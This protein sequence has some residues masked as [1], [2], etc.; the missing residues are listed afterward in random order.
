MTT[1]TSRDPWRIHAYG[2]DRC[3]LRRRYLQSSHASPP[4]YPL[5]ATKAKNQIL[6]LLW[7][8]LF[9]SA[10]HDQR[11]SEGVLGKRLTGIIPHRP[12]EHPHGPHKGGGSK[13]NVPLFVHHISDRQKTMTAVA[14]PLRENGAESSPLPRR[15]EITD[16]RGHCLGMLLSCRRYEIMLVL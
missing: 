15:V 4:M 2:R 7:A 8:T 12:I 9:V 14:P 16:G 11:I 1:S 13:K 3:N 5:G 10:S 6:P